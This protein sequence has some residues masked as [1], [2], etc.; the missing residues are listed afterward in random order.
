VDLSLFERW[1]EQAGTPTLGATS[2]YD[3]QKQEYTLSFAQACAPSPGQPEKRPF[4]IPVEIG[5]LDEDG[6]DLPLQLKDQ[7]DAGS[8][9]LNL[10]VQKEKEDF[11]LAGVTQKPVPSFLRG[12]SAPVKLTYDYSD[13]ELQ[14]LMA[15]DSDLFNRWDASHKLC[16]KTILKLVD[17]YQNNKALHLD[18]S[19]VAAFGRLL[20]QSDLDKAFLAEVLNIPSESFI[21]DHMEVVDV[22]AIHQVR[23]FM[24]GVLAKT[25]AQAFKDK[26]SALKAGEK[27]LLD[28]AAM[29]E[30]ALKNICLA[31]LMQI[32]TSEVIDLCYLQFHECLT[33]TDEIAA[34]GLLCSCDVDERQKAIDSFYDKWG[35]DVVVMNKWFSVQAASKLA[36]TVQRVEMLCEHSAFDASNPN[37]VRSLVGVFARNQRRFHD[38]SGRGYTFLADQLLDIDSRNPQ[39]AG[40]MATLFNKWKRFDAQRQDLMREQLERIAAKPGL[41]SN[42][43]EVVGRAL[44]N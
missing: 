26:Y 41:T 39:L 5:L 38:I 1:Y 12:F 33:M 25:H 30:R 6:A 37:K 2:S 17:D 24:I 44:A 34:L 15:Y 9:S 4:P 3:A 31:Y 28:P 14:H 18:E 19:F 11:T 42:V 43:A 32:E 8:T 21:G 35:H 13:A 27:G 7:D 16:L 40:R 10:L 29:G 22:E 23:E 36:N 20:A